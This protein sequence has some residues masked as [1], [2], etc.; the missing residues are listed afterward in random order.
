MAALLDADARR[1]LADAILDESHGPLTPARRE[2]A[3]ARLRQ[4][5]L[6]HD[7]AQGPRFDD[8]AV[9]GIL[10][11]SAPVRPSGPLR[12][13]DEEGRIDRYPLKAPD[14]HELL[15]WVVGQAFRPGEVL[16]EK[17]VNE[18]LAGFTPDVAGLR[19]RLVDEG[20]L[21]R[22]RSGSEYAPVFEE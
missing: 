11:E 22:T 13:L 4:S 6:I 3:M 19:R 17:A 5:G 15:A 10:D 12:F 14:R 9:R 8:A 16:D 7:T 1:A 2:R 18:R 21:E 20:M